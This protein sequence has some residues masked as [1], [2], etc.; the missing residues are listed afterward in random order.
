[1]LFDSCYHLNSVNS[2]SHLGLPHKVMDVIALRKQSGDITGEVLLNGFSQ[3]SISFRRCSGYVEQFD[4]QSAELTVRETITFSAALRLDRTDPVFDA[5]DGVQNH[6]S[7]IIDMLE[8][9]NEAD[10]L[11]GNAEEGG[12]TFEQKKRLSIAAEL[13]ASPSVL[14]LGE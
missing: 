2:F 8:L 5:P 11:V 13:A 12:L 4:V 10:L 1:M 7:L 3:N 14:F 9:T 6:V